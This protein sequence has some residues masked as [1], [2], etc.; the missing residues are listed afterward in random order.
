[1]MKQYKLKLVV[2]VFF[3]FCMIFYSFNINYIRGRASCPDLYELLRDITG[4][5]Y[6][7]SSVQGYLVI[8]L[9]LFL[10]LLNI[11]IRIH[12]NSYMILRKRTRLQLLKDRRN[13]LIPFTLC[14]VALHIL[15]LIIGCY[16]AVGM[17]TCKDLAFF[18]LLHGVV[19]FIFYCN[20]GLW[21]YLFSDIFQNTE[22]AII[23]V[24][25]LFIVFYFYNRIVC[26]YSFIN[27]LMVMDALL[28]HK[29]TY[30]KLF[31]TILK[32]IISFGLLN[33]IDG[34]VIKRR[35]ILA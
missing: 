11:L 25:L 33:Y 17:D 19:I 7:Y 14:F 26:N 2:G 13:V 29:L 8:Y 22:K 12:E 21:F 5:I 34:I 27:D 30:V 1:M 24:S 16:I 23:F 4:G 28:S 6:G 20:V 18:A 32:Y 35:D 15:V 9:I 3:S 31:T 10:V